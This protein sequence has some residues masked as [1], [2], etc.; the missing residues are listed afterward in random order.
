M[1]LLRDTPV[2]TVGSVSMF[3]AMM[4]ETE[5]GTRVRGFSRFEA[6]TKEQYLWLGPHVLETNTLV[7]VTRA[8]TK[9]DTEMVW[10]ALRF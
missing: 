9:D 6:L 5:T 4:R 3:H 7:D 2:G 1:G 8:R 10:R